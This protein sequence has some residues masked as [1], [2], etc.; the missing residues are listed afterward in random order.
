[1]K[2]RTKKGEIKE[3]I[4]NEQQLYNYGLNR[5]SSRDYLRAE[6]FSKMSN[7]QPNPDMIN[8]VLDKLETLGYI[9]DKR[10]IRS[11]FNAYQLKESL[12]KTKNRLLQKG[13]TKDL[14]E[15]VLFDLEE[16]NKNIEYEYDSQTDS[17]L[18]LLEKKFKTY[19]LDNRDKML[20]F[21]ISKGY[22]YTLCSK[23]LKIFQEKND[24]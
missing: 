3:I 19:Q 1:M 16:E 23:V 12:N 13:A 14:I 7:L 15:E 10:K 11:V 2:I 5:L 8:K 4:Y 21:L 17:A 24:V 18:I 9:N 20:R 22:N 6:L